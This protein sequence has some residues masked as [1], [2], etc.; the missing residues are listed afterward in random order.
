MKKYRWLGVIFL[1]LALIGTQLPVPVVKAINA[2]SDF[3][4][5]GTILVQYIGTQKNVSIPDGVTEIATEAFVDCSFIESIALPNSLTSINSLAFSGCSSLSVVTLPDGTV[6]LGSQAFYGCSNLEIMYFGDALQTISEGVF[7]GCTKLKNVIISDL[8]TSFSIEKGAVYNYDKSKLYFMCPGD[9]NVTFNMPSTVKDIEKYAF[10]GCTHIERVVLSNSLTKIPAFSFTN[11]TS[12]KEITFPYSITEIEMKAFAYCSSLKE[13]IIPP[14]IKNIHET[15]FDYCTNL[16]FS[17]NSGDYA[18]QFYENNK[19]RF[20]PESLYPIKENS[21]D[22]S[23]ITPIP[24]DITGSI[25]SNEETNELGSSIIV[26][27]GVYVLLDDLSSGVI[28]GY[29]NVVEK[30]YGTTWAENFIKDGRLLENSFYKQS[31]L[32]NISLPENLTTIGEFSFARS[33]LTSIILPENIKTIEYAAFYHCDDLDQIIVPKNVESIGGHAFDHTLWM[34]TWIKEGATDYLIVGDGILIAY[35]GTTSNITIPDEVKQIAAFTFE[36]HT[37]IASIEGGR[38]IWKVD[39]D[40][41]KDCNV[42]IEEGTKT[43]NILNTINTSFSVVQVII[44]K[45]PIAKLLIIKWLFIFSSL[46][47][48]IFFIAIKSIHKIEENLPL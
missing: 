35:K 12:L 1:V 24:E 38:N 16:V 17:T 40:A 30:L 9:I 7:I 31:N 18:L 29:N 5:D 37:E 44:Y 11:C 27:D 20:K 21:T 45:E 15:A 10:W 22:N 33:G 32:K 4:L 6:S 48:G 23:N 47:A 42:K 36:G 28:Q 19:N 26:A 41:F 2:S 3:I 46:I 13:V 39:K 14:P 34:D 25:N 43:Q 8:N